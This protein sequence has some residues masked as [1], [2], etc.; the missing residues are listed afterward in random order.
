M[1]PVRKEHWPFLVRRLHSLTG[2]L[3][4]GVFFVLHLSI[5]ATA[6]QGQ[7]AFD[8]AVRRLQGL[9][10]L[11][12]VEAL[13]IWIP[14]AVHAGLGI[15]ITLRSRSNVRTYPFEG[16]WSYTLQRAS[17]VATLAFLV[18]HVRSLRMQVAL[19]RLHPSDLF[20]TL[21]DELSATTEAGIP[22]AAAL[23]LAGLGAASYHLGNGIG[24]FC[25]TW[26]LV[27]TP[28]GARIAGVVSGLIGALAFL[29]GASTVVYYVTGSRWFFASA[30]GSPP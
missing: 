6:M 4:V 21:A 26:G 12:A 5:N 13:G 20:T 27:I 22:L 25:S 29:L 2:A 24:R 17:G 28:R 19:G 15:L 9:P 3:P 18:L 16:N 10:G 11:I 1:T 23:Y 7:S 14:L 8:A 30:A